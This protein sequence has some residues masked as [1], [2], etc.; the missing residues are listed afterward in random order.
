MLGEGVDGRALVDAAMGL[1]PLDPL[2]Y[3]MLGVRSFSH[4]ALDQPEEAVFWAERSARAPRAHPLIDLLAAVAHG[5]N[6]D[7]ARAGAWAR[8]AQARR[9]GLTGADFL[10][11]FPFQDPPTRSRITDTLRRMN[12]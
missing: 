12:L 5:L 10:I 11:A 4:M 2:L 1:S 3:G 7:D 9:P 6:G 8:S